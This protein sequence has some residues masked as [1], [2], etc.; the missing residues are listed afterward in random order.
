MKEKMKEI[1][2]YKITKRKTINEKKA[3]GFIHRVPLTH[4]SQFLLSS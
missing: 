1:K 4:S 2:N 3:I